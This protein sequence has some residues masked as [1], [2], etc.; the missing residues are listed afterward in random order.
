MKDRDLRK[1]KKYTRQVSKLT[2]N[3]NIYL[4]IR[5]SDHNP[6]LVSE[7]N[8]FPYM[9]IIFY[10]T[11]NI[12]GNSHKK[13]YW[14]PRVRRIYVYMYTHK[15]VYIYTVHNDSIHATGHVWE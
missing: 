7:F 1:H 5:I 11:L 6:P 8:I 12:L 4:Y 15:C 10:F 3:E 14:I 2:Y 13:K 9:P